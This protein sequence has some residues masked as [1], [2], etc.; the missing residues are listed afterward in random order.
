[1][2]CAFN[3]IDEVTKNQ[4]PLARNKKHKGITMISKHTIHALALAA[5]TQ[6]A[7]KL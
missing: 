4:T 6:L 1:M 2:R 7:G 5:L 3:V